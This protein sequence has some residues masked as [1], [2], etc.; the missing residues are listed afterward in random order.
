MSMTRFNFLRTLIGAPFAAKAI[1]RIITNGKAAP[2]PV[3]MKPSVQNAWEYDTYPGRYAISGCYDQILLTG[4][5][6]QACSGNW[7]GV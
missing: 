4:C 3:P 6:P 1:E 7:R 2:A 5:S